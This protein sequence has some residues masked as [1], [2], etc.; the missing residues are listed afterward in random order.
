M[1]QI[2]LEYTLQDLQN[3]DIIENILADV[4]SSI[5][6]DLIVES[7]LNNAAKRR[8]RQ[9]YGPE[10]FLMPD[11]LKYPIINSRTGKKDQALLHAAYIDL[12]RK[13]GITGTGDLA[14]KARDMLDENS[15][16]V[17]IGS[18]KIPLLEY[19]NLIS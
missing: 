8:L 14:Q 10:A 18:D 15:F 1:K 19:I 9:K 13:S 12:K 5:G 17:E 16:L 6:Y 11:K 2:V 4:I 3:N 7:F